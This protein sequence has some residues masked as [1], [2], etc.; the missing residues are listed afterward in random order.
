[1]PKDVTLIDYLGFLPA[2]MLVA[3]RMAGLVLTVPVLSSRSIPKTIK[4]YFV[5]SVALA[6]FP[7]IASTIPRSITLGQA[8]CGLFGELMFGALLGLGVSLVLMSAQVAG[9][10]VARPAGLAISNVI[11]PM[12]GTS[13]PVLGQIYLIMSSMIFI[14][15]GG[16]QEL[17]RIMI[18][19]FR[20]VPLLGVHVDASMMEFLVH[21][22]S[23]AFVLAVQ[24][25]AP[26]I[27][28]LLMTSMALG[29]LSRTMPQFNV[30]SVGFSVKVS[31]ALLVLLGTLSLASEMIEC[32]FINFFDL[33]REVVR[34]PGPLA[35]QP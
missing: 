13:T 32:S 15:I 34:V 11:D 1:M 30:L 27:I 24:L 33:L 14:A 12:S 23:A 19:S 22:L 4:A 16:L 9:M 5:V 26:G 31:M 18:D 21:S 17:V 3:A 10:T 29:Y 25:A 6:V 28:A 35:V 7:M 2:F 8:L 20:A